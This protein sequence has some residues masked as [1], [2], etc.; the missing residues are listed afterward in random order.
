MKN[1]IQ[2]ILLFLFIIV[3]NNLIAKNNCKFGDNNTY[4]G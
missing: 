3:T 2:T 4:R 1:K